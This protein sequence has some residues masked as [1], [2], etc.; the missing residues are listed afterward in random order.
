M[1]VAIS[2]RY[3]AY[4]PGSAGDV[5]VVVNDLQ[6]PKALAATLAR[7]HREEPSTRI[8]LLAPQQPPSGY[9]RRHLRHVNVNKVLRDMATREMEPLAAMLQ[10]AGVP[11]HQ[12]V[13]V[14]PWLD[15]ICDFARDLGCRR[16]FLGDNRANFLKNLL[17]RHDCALLR[18]RM[19]RAG[20]RCR[21]MRRE[22]GMGAPRPGVEGSR[23]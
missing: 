10:S 8:H 6:D 21:V 18:A 19:T 13:Q 17:L 1:A 23:A 15:T 4:F 9:A 5:L 22:E 7:I 3:I 2:G 12:H 20:F 11:H 14:G 16:V